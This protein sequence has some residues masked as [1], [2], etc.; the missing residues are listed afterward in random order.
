MADWTANSNDALHLSLG[1]IFCDILAVFSGAHVMRFTV[2]ANKDKEVL[3]DGESF[4][5]FH[6]TFTYPVRT[7]FP[8]FSLLT[9]LNFGGDSDIWRRREYIWVLGPCNRCARCMRHSPRE[10]LLNEPLFSCA[11]RPVLSPSFSTSD[12]PRRSRPP[13]PSTTFGAR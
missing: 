5:N 11:L 13:R 2:R 4:E 6:P 3:S 8:L 9:P 1:T 10:S 7:N 12:I